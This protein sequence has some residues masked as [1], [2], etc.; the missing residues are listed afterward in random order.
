[1]FDTVT[2][3]ERLPIDC[4]TDDGDVQM[5]E[6]LTEEMIEEY[7]KTMID[8]VPPHGSSMQIKRRTGKQEI[9][10]DEEPVGVHDLW[11][12]AW[13][14]IVIPESAMKLA[15]AVRKHLLARR[16]TQ[17][18]SDKD[19]KTFTLRESVA[20]QQGLLDHYTMEWIGE[21][22]GNMERHMMTLQND[23][24]TQPLH[25]IFPDNRFT[26]ELRSHRK[27]V[28]HHRQREKRFPVQMIRNQNPRHEDTHDT[29]L[30]PGQRAGRG[31]CPPSSF[32]DDIGE[33]LTNQMIFQTT[34]CFWSM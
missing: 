1:M 28:E 27:H 3:I 20:E 4:H 33:E 34:R 13:L 25:Y 5:D 9:K 31:F 16:Y 29:H 6:E 2:R 14:Q 22:R 15:T 32:T 23:R 12:L 26:I 30:Q 17:I 8:K 19:L 21:A 18:R 11:N 10:A 7:R 24:C